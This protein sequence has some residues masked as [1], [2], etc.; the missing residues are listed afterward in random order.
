MKDPLKT[1]ATCFEQVALFFPSGN[2]KFQENYLRRAA[3]LDTRDYPREILADTLKTYHLQLGANAKT[4]MLIEELRRKETLVVITGQQAGMLTGPLY[5]LYK[6]MTTIR[7]AKEQRDRLGRPVVPIFWIAS[8]DHDW[9]EICETE[10]LNDQGRTMTCRIPG[11][12]G[13]KSVG[14]QPVPCWTDIENQL[15]K[16]LPDCEYRSEVMKQCH[17]FAEKA[18]NL[19]Q[20]FALTL[21]WLV[22]KWGLIFFDPMLPE[23]K[24]LAIPIYRQILEKHREVTK[25]LDVRTKEWLGLGFEPQIKP[26]G[27]EINLFLSV[28]ERKAIIFTDS[29]YSLRGHEG[30]LTLDGINDILTQSPERVSPNVVT[31][32][33]VQESLFPTLAY[34]PGPGELNYWAQ[35]GKVFS[36]FDFVMP[37]LYP[38]LSAVVLTASWQKSLRKETLT[39]DDVYRGLSEHRERSIREQ[40]LLDIDER[41]MRVR[42]ILEKAYLELEPLEGIH[43]NVH[44]WLA[45]N[46]GKVEFQ[47]NYLKKKIWQAQRKQCSEVLKRLQQLENGITPNHSRQE[48][49]LNPLSFIV[50]YGLSFV[51]RIAELPLS[52]DFFEQQILM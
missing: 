34:V 29:N 42:A 40:D 50:R 52:S 18:E 38:R 22:Q 33:V 20:W 37:I 48:R 47:L 45:R 51:D 3:Y 2:P 10:M 43:V 46:E 39:V 19:T 35:L 5:T 30:E 36:T 6:A 41:F 24:R 21:Q 31:R 1:M 11:E 27:G 49:V 7:L 25:A 9:L 16:S 23:F 4:L 12:G 8:E 14:N 13:G 17:V 44:E 26:L 32:P 28:P 15:L